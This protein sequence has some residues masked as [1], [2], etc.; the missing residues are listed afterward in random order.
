MP[1][2]EYGN[3]V[4]GIVQKWVRAL[5]P[6]ARSVLCQSGY[7]DFFEFVNLCIVVCQ[8]VNYRNLVGTSRDPAL[9][10]NVLV[11]LSAQYNQLTGGGK[12]ITY[13]QLA[14]FFQQYLAYMPHQLAETFSQVALG[15]SKPT[16]IKNT[17]PSGQTVANVS[18]AEVG[19]LIDIQ[20]FLQVVHHVVLPDGKYATSSASPQASRLHNCVA[21]AG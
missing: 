21:V 7:L 9:V 6:S 10:K 17:D 11:M 1:C 19:G 4:Q 8:H 18:T 16:Y 13:T 2:G 14:D 20:A 15:S 3:L 12:H 5:Q